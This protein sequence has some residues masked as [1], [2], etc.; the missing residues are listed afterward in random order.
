MVHAA[1]MP[2]VA[3]KRT[4]VRKRK[5]EPS[6][7][8]Y[9]GKLHKKVHGYDTE[10]TLSA[11]AVQALDTMAEHSI[12]QM[13]KHAKLVLSYEGGTTFSPKLAERATVLMLTDA[14]RAE[15][16]TRGGDAVAKLEKELEMK[17][18]E[19]RAKKKQRA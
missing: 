13:L 6:F 4:I 15:A 11:G 9:I 19:T 3:P 5:V 17:A 12:N 2:E 7:A 10:L 16:K 1:A 14:L 18:N 8:S